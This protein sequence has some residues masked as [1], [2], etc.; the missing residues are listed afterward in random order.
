MLVDVN[1]SFYIGCQSDILIAM[2]TCFTVFL[3]L[4]LCAP[5]VINAQ[6]PNATLGNDT[7]FCEGSALTLTAPTS[8]ATYLWST[9]ETTQSITVFDAGE[10]HVAVTLSGCT[11]ADTIAVASEPTIWSEFTYEKTSDCLP[12][13]YAFTDLSTACGGSI[14]GWLWEFGDGLISTDQHPQHEFAND[15][16]YVVKLT[17]TDNNG[18]SIR[19]SKRITVTSITAS[20][21]L[22]ADTTI[23]FGSGL[24]LDAAHPGYQY[25][26]STGE[27]TQQ[28]TV[29]DDGEYSV[30]ITNGSCQ[31]TDTI[32]VTT[33][34]SISARW[35]YETGEAC[36]PVSVKFTDS[37]SVY[38]GQTITGW[39][40]D[41]GDGTYS[42][43]QHPVHSY[44]S[45]DSFLVRL[46]VTSSNGSST[47]RSR[48][49][50]INN[51]EY[52]PDLSAELKVCSGESLQVDAGVAN[53]EYLWTPS[54]GVSAVTSRNPFIKPM[55][56]AW[57]T[58]NVTKCMVQ[59]SD[60][61]YIIVDSI[62]KPVV[63]Q[64]NNNLKAKHAAAY[65]WYRDGQKIHGA[66][67]SHLRI[68]RQAYYAVRIYNASG[69]W[70]ES[71]PVYFLPK[72]GKEISLEDIIIKCS[73]N[74]TNGPF[75][76]LLSAVPA[77]PAVVSVYNRFGIVLYKTNIKGHATPLNIPGASRGLYYVEVA[78]GT[79]KRILP[80]IVR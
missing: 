72:S 78:V 67:R 9:G 13:T 2:K 12:V 48:W 66:E 54:F 53:A 34:T 19:R 11:V 59:H 47:G 14:A 20:V 29:F 22:G 51:T 32:R 64:H 56:D 50:I 21:Y 69:C 43:E 39:S 3:L 79:K 7:S 16:Q 24:T 18:N 77:E 6:C 41:F 42:N 62:D 44:N 26:W 4:I 68:D 57:Y 52:K 71:D 60:S 63:I 36:L 27:T 75:N 23:C 61:V 10:Y 58:V 33:S 8:G 40:W 73:P 70:R 49:L 17:V 76:L 45:A 55:V 28:I 30:V 31:A 65:E 15:G 46:T 80:L 35:G 5:E 25:L 1:F 38:C 37:S 74:P